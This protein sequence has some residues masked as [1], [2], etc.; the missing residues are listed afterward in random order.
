MIV[1]VKSI[2]REILPETNT[3]LLLK[4]SYAGRYSS[5]PEQY[6]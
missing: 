3:N 4:R 2:A 5:A 6:A 1:V